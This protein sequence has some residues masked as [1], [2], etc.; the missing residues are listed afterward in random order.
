[1]TIIGD[2]VHLKKE[3]LSRCL[4]PRHLRQL[5]TSDTAASGYTIDSGGPSFGYFQCHMP[6]P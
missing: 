3:R 4:E 6:A 1:M 5:K 2:I